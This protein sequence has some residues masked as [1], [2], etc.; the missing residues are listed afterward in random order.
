MKFGVTMANVREIR[1]LKIVQIGNSKGI[2]LPKAIIDKYGFSD[3]LQVEESD[4]GIFLRSNRRDKLSWD[5]TYRAMKNEK[6][7][8]DDFDGVIND[9]L[10][11]DDLES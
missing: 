11:G 1:Q 9:G 2:R 6:E 10:E 5:D 8:W 7:D 3:S 4:E